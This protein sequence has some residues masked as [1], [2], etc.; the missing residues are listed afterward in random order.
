[1]IDPATRKL[2][3]WVADLGDIAVIV[4][5]FLAAALALLLHG[6]RREAL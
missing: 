3:V 1:M 4:P 2:L 6:R 5:A